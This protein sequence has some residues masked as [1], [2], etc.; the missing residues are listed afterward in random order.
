L[1]LIGSNQQI[2]SEVFWSHRFL[3]N[4][5]VQQHSQIFSLPFTKW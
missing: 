3:Q 4:S 5:P 2:D 1:P